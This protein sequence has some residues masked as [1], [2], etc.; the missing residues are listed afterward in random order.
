MRYS[1]DA[2]GHFF[3]KPTIFTPP[4]DPDAAEEEQWVDVD[5]DSDED[6]D[7]QLPA[8]PKLDDEEYTSDSDDEGDS[9]EFRVRGLR[10]GRGGWMML[11]KMRR[12]AAPRP[13][14]K[15]ILNFLGYSEL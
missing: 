7:G 1:P 13:Q 12:M 2:V 15:D 10:R 5:E 3:E 14:T 8:A 9:I 11:K 6:E 4:V